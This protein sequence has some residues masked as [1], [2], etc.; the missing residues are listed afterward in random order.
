[1]VYYRGGKILSVQKIT[2]L[3][4]MGFVL[5]LPSTALKNYVWNS[6]QYDKCTFLQ[7]HVPPLTLQQFYCNVWNNLY[8]SKL[9][10]R[11]LKTLMRQ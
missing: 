8:L 1:M 11:I 2:E 9:L 6:A 10:F 5:N 3:V 7:G 4:E